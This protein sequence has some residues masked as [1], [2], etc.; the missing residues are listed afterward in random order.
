MLAK[1]RS[2]NNQTKPHCKYMSIYAFIRQFSE[3]PVLSI[4]FSDR[5]FFKNPMMRPI[6]AH[7]VLW[8][9]I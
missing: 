4:S 3:Y 1:L 2:R 6:S 8:R 5:Y 9:V 7:L